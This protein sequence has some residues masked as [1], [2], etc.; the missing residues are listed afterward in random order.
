MQS[1]TATYT[2]DAYIIINQYSEEIGKLKI[3]NDNEI[4][5]FSLDENYQFKLSKNKVEVLKNGKKIDD[6]ERFKNLGSFQSKNSE[7]SI[8]GISSWKGGTKIVDR[9]NNTLVKLN[10]KSAWIDKGIYEFETF[11]EVEPYQLALMLHLHI[12]GSKAKTAIVAA[13]IAATVVI[14]IN[15]FN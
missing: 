11:T 1:F 14:V 8:K 6:F 15:I 7:L 9:N 2:E 5:F 12:Q 10:N 13:S 3:V 4:R